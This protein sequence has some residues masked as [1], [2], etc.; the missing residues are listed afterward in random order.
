MRRRGFEQRH[1]HRPRDWRWGEGS[2]G[3]HPSHWPRW[4]RRRQGV[5]FLRFA[6]VFGIL[7]ILVLGGM[8][9]AAFLLANLAG[10]DGST[11][12]LVWF[13]GCGLALTPC[14][15]WRL[16]WQP[17]RFVALPDPWPN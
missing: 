4:K 15:C 5:W 9:A 2:S 17:G 1:Q 6:T 11:A 3:S 8:A 10:A 16:R 7:L 14:H 12:L 13:A